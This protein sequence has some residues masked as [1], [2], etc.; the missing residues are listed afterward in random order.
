MVDDA[1]LT[2]VSHFGAN[3]NAAIEEALALDGKHQP[4]QPQDTTATA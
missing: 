3:P 2:D 4:R 1:P